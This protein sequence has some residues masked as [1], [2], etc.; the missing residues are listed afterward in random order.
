MEQAKRPSATE[1]VLIW[2][3]WGLL[4]AALILLIE[5]ASERPHSTLG[6]A[7]FFS[8]WIVWGGFV[9]FIQR[10]IQHRY[11]ITSRFYRVVA[12]NRF[13][14]FAVFVGFMFALAYVLWRMATH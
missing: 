13:A 8:W 14:W 7:V 6:L 5:R 12:R 10:F 3:A 4:T 1:S 2:A 11:Q 9:G